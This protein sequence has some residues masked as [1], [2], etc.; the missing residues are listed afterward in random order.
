MHRKIPMG[1][2]YFEMTIRL[3]Y[4]ELLANCG[5]FGSL[6]GVPFTPFLGSPLLNLPNVTTS[7][8][9]T[10]SSYSIFIPKTICQ[11]VHQERVLN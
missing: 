2:D 1:K 7:K 5:F 6:D 8:I 10:S 3:C 9:N 4:M 11:Q